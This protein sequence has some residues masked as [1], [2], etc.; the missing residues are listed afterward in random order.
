MHGLKLPKCC[1]ICPPTAVPG[2]YVAYLTC[3]YLKNNKLFQMAIDAYFWH[4][5][6]V[7]TIY[8]DTFR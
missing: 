4:P 6:G 1:P 8:R 2:R 5:N 7:L 3:G